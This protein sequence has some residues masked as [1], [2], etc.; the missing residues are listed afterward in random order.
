MT[1]FKNQL[2]QMIE[3]VDNFFSGEKIENLARLDFLAY[4]DQT[5]KEILTMDETILSEWSYYAAIG[6][7]GKIHFF[8]GKPFTAFCAAPSDATLAALRAAR[9]IQVEVGAAAIWKELYEKKNPKAGLA[10]IA[11]CALSVKDAKVKHAIKPFLQ[12]RKK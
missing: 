10:V 2:E 1:D 5:L 11:L 6:F 8:E 3:T 12:L 7:L 9:D 4:R